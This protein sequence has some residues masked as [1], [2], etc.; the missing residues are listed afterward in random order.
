MKRNVAVV[1]YLSLDDADRGWIESF[2]ARHDPQ[3]G[4][5]SAHFTLVF[6][7]DVATIGVAN[8]VEATAHSIDAFDFVI[9]SAKA[10]RNPLGLGG[11]VFLVP[12]EGSD[13]VVALH[14]RLCAGVFRSS[15][16]PDLS[17]LP[18]VTVAADPDWRKCEAL[19]DDLNRDPRVPRGRVEALVLLDLA[20]AQWNQWA[21]FPS[22]IPEAGSAAG[23]AS[24]RCSHRRRGPR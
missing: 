12:D 9:R 16:R 17:Y 22:V 20:G 4:K 15:L 23:A 10:V 2:R 21:S 3:A 14:D 8:D 24:Q 5:L 1:A 6:P 11:H 19:A 13:Q 18:H 7:T